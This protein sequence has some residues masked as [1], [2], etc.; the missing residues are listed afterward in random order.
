MSCRHKNVTCLNHYDTFRKYLCHDCGEVWM[1]ECERELAL[2]FLPH[3]TRDGRE[4]CTGL[5]YPVSG[6]AKN[7]CLSC[8]GQREEEHPRAAI[9]GQKG[10]VERFYWREIYKTYLESVRF[11]LEEQEI[12]VEDIIDFERKFPKTAKLMKKEAKKVWQ[13]RHKT[14]PLYDLKELTEAAFLSKVKVPERFV[15]FEYV[16]LLRRN[17][18]I[19]RWVGQ[20]GNLLAVEDVVAEW[21]EKQGFSVMKCERKLINVLVSTFCA[22]VILD[23]TDPRR[24]VRV[25]HPTKWLTPTKRATAILRGSW[26]TDFGSKEY[27]IRRSKDF[28]TLLESLEKTDMK[29]LFEKLLEPSKPLRIYLGADNNEALE[30]GRTALRVMP[31]SMILKCIDWAIRYFWGRQSGWAD[32]FIFRDEEYK[33]VEVK[34]P[35]DEL[36]LDQMQW[37]KWAVEEAHIPCEILRVKKATT[38]NKSSAT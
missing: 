19:G 21:Y 35:Y 14:N 26:G 29:E 13:V 10:K 20:K 31:Q 38:N 30:L 25:S 28:T 37:F 33:F 15:D 22:P 11:F 1:C 23:P 32:L 34:S 36:S 9:Y 17:R 12:T 7:I 8:R 3:Q 18:K 5:Y 6:F 2:Q 16:L 24:I 4:Y 27:F